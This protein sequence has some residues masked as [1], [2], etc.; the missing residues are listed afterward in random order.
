MK[1]AKLK[2]PFSLESLIMI[3]FY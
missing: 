3:S 1:E 2:R